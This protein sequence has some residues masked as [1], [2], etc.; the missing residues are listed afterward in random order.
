MVISEKE[1]LSARYLHEKLDIP[2][3]YLTNLLHRLGEH[4]YLLSIQGKY[5]GYKFL[6]KPEDISIYDIVV[7]FDGES[8]FT[9]CIL[10]LNKCSDDH[11]CVMHIEWNKIKQQ[12]ID[13]LVHT[14]LK[15]LKANKDMRITNLGFNQN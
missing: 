5:G 4:K 3:K 12:S 13:L 9:D 8:T 2:Y 10:G 6:K 14:T 1:L 11:P 15:D 7:Q